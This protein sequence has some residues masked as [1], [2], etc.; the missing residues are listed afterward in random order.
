MSEISSFCR[1]TYDISFPLTQKMYVIFIRPPADCAYPFCCLVFG[2]VLR[3]FRFHWFLFTCFPLP[4][5]LTATK[6]TQSILSSRRQN[7]VCW[8]EFLNA[9]N[10]FPCP[11]THCHAI[12]FISLFAAFLA[13]LKKNR[14][15]TEWR[16]EYCQA[17]SLESLNSINVSF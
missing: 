8:G 16:F 14:G 13:G 10:G 11:P 2:C 5:T 12:G 1:N 9:F 15:W 3:P 6:S 7:R 17:E 4:E